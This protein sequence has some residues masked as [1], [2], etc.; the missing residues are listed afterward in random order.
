MNHHD[1]GL[2]LPTRHEQF[3]SVNLLANGQNSMAA[4]AWCAAAAHAA[5]SSNSASNNQTSLS[6][7]NSPTN[8]SNSSVSSPSFTSSSSSNQSPTTQQFNPNF[9]QY[10]NQQQFQ[11]NS[12][13]QN[14]FTNGSPLTNFMAYNPFVSSSNNLLVNPTGSL[15][16]Q[17][18]NS[19][20]TSTSNGM[21]DHR[22]SS[23]AALRLKAREHSVALGTI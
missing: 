15:Y 8:L 2:T 18:V 23:I 13:N 5:N 7:N 6:I 12:S 14:L 22:T 16:S 4:V 17:V 3:N 20:N 9:N 19:N 10:Q 11:N 21:S 1:V